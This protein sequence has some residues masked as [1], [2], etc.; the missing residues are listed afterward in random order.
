MKELYYNTMMSELG[1]FV[2]RSYTINTIM[3]ELG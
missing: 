3:S 2:V 1:W